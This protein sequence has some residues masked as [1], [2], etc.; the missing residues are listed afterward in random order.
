MVAANQGIAVV[1]RPLGDMP[2][3]IKILPI[4]GTVPAK[5]PIYL[6]WNRRTPLP[7]AALR[8]RDFILQRGPVFDA[9]RH[10]T[11]QE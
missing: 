7:P 6:L 1:P 2:Y 4:T 10:C 8:L 9:Y 11:H 3:P 5:R